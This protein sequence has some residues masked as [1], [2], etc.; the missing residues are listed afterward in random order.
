MCFTSDPVKHLDV[1][2]PLTSKETNYL[3]DLKKKKKTPK[4]KNPQTPTKTKLKP[5][6][7]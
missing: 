7:L 1:L 5:N 2:C 3:Q 6:P 4:Q